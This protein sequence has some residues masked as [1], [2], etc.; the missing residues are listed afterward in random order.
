MVTYAA[1]NIARGPVIVKGGVAA[2]AFEK[3]NAYTIRGNNAGIP[4]IPSRRHQHIQRL[5]TTSG[6][7]LLSVLVLSSCASKNKPTTPEEY[8]QAGNRQLGRNRQQQARQYYQELLENFP[9]SHYKTEAQFNIAESLYREKSY[10]EARFEYQKFLELHPLHPLASRAQFQIGM[11]SLQ[12]IQR[13]DRSQR[14]T[15]EGLQAFRLLRRKYPQD[16]LVPQA[17]AHIHVLRAH[18]AKRELSVARFYYKKRAYHA[19]IGRL[20]NLIQLYPTT[21]DLDEALYMLADSYRA[22][23]NYVKTQ[24]VLRLL[25][26][27]FPTSKYVSRARAQLRQLPNT[28]ITLQ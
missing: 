26:D 12:Q 6:V 3:Y 5:L 27:R 15:Q 10:L 8:I 25:V 20:L 16:P 13:Y 7:L 22:E 14:H 9:D 21:S 19:A 11:C 28:G 18:L 2:F 4:M 24:R 17:E 1:L 23:E